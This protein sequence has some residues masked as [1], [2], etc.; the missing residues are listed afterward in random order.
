MTEPLLCSIGKSLHRGA[1]RILDFDPG[2]ASPGTI[3]KI[4]AEYAFKI[5]AKVDATAFQ[6]GVP[7]MNALPGHHVDI[8]VARWR[9]SRRADLRPAAAP[10]SRA[11]SAQERAAPHAPRL[12]PG[13]SGRLAGACQGETRNGSRKHSAPCLTNEVE[14]PGGTHSNANDGIRRSWSS[15][16]QAGAAGSG[17]LFTIRATA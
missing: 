7:A 1:H 8:I 17:G 4:A 14:C 6:S 5:V 11:P 15:I 2:F 10:Q 9:R 16:G 12:R 13:E 3:R